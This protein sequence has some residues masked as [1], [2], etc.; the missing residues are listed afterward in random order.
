M[1]KQRTFSDVEYDGRKRVSRRERLPHPG[2]AKRMRRKLKKF[3]KLLAQGKMSHYDWRA[4]CQSWRGNYM[5]RFNARYRV[6]YMD[7]LYNELFINCRDVAATEAKNEN[8]LSRKKR[9]RSGLPHKS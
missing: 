8:G 9:E 6:S 4:A 1:K 5:K 7:S 2:S 3:K